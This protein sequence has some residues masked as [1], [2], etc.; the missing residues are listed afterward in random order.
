MS[1]MDYK[2][3]LITCYLAYKQ[4]PY[5]ISET[6][7]ERDHSFADI[8]TFEKIEFCNDD[9]MRKILPADIYAIWQSR[10]ELKKILVKQR[11]ERL[12]EQQRAGLIG[13]C[14]RC[15]GEMKPRLSH[16]AFSRRVNVYICSPCGMME[17]LED[18]G[19]IKMP[20]VNWF[21]ARPLEEVSS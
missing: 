6:D 21:I 12:F 7:F 19:D 10:L 5:D 20:V 13:I 8:D 2:Q 14:P 17:A 1:N 3:L 4:I 11:I 16:N 15:G 18:F 9:Y